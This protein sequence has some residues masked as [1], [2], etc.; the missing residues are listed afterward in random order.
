MGVRGGGGVMWQ[1]GV[2]FIFGPPHN[3]IVC[4]ANEMFHDNHC[5][6]FMLIGTSTTYFT[7]VVN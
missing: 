1:E 3:T 4:P 2:E 6:N 5:A 7:S